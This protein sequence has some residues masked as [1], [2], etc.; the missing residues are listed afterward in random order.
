[1]PF[2]WIEKKTKKRETFSRV[3]R[4]ARSAGWWDFVI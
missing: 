2:K 1:M 3:K 4:P